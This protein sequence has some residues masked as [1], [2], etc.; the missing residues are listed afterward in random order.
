MAGKADALIFFGAS[1]DLAYKQIFPAL[2][3]L[4]AAGDLDVP[5]VG[6][7]YSGSGWTV[8][9]LRNRARAS[10]EEH[11][12]VDEVAFA[13]MA[14]LM[15]YVD[16]EY[17]D[18][19][20]FEALGNILGDAHTLVHYLAIP[21]SLF[22]TVIKGLADAG[23]NKCSRIVV[24]KPFGRDLQSADSLNELL[25]QYFPE[26]SIYRIDHYLGKDPVENIIYTRF[27][28]P[29]FEPM[30]NRMHVQSMQIT[31]AEA[32]GVKDRGSFYDSVGALRDV[33][34]NHLLAVTSNICM[35]PPSSSHPDAV[36]DARSMLLKAV[37]PMTPRDLIRGQ[38]EGYRD[39]RGVAPGSTTE[40]FI[41]GRIFIDNWRWADVPIYVRSGKHLPVTCTE[42][43]IRFRRPP[44]EIF[45]EV[46]PATSSYVRIR[47]S[48][49]IAFAMG[50]RIK[51]PGDRMVGEDVELSLAEQADKMMPPYERL[52][53]DA[54]RGNDQLFSREDLVN[55]QWNV[56]D[57]VLGDVTP[58][59]AYQQ[60]SWGPEEAQGLIGSD[61]PWINPQ[62]G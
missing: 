40:T 14:S 29:I 32:F 46:V 10:L 42:V 34:Q 2:Q 41:A 24:E 21:P 55:A 23:C 7:A 57:P 4:V 59:Y 48:P 18:P 56:V 53:G 13:K 39:E 52:L 33:F 25:H 11:G 43:R 61:A 38:Y 58:V 16:G 35:D 36:R 15:R 12:G 19:S 49:D 62:V 27:A 51:Q 50:V 44:Q 5:I 31:M 3:L 17:Q 30:W 6:V 8:D 26:E 47:I 20:T 54:L 45:G 37:R 60:G 28:N 1:G 22:G 9:D